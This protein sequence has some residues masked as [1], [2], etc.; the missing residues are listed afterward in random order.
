[1]L[2]GYSDS[3]F[4]YS[5][6][7][8]LL[9]ASMRVVAIDQRGHGR[10]ERA[11]DYSMD[12]MAED[13][14]GLMD[15]LDIPSATIVGHSMGSFVA[16]RVAALAPSR[17]TSLVLVGAGPSARNG[18]ILEVQKAVDALR[19]PVDPAFVREFQLSTVARPVPEAFMSAAIQESHRLDAATWKAVFAGLI[20]YVPAE[21]QIRV[22]TLVLG[23]DRDGVFSVAEQRELTRAIAGARSVIVAGVGHALHWEE[24]ERFV[25]ELLQ[26]TASPGRSGA[27][28]E[29]DAASP[30]HDLDHSAAAAGIG[31]RVLR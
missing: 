19:D 2:H 24:P 1:M 13:V 7:L 21:P 6:V 30:S 23:G 15:A 29:T 10:S 17:I 25:S 3:A 31:V 9:P 28:N 27:T 14:I 4:S 26:F 20:A 18:A 11:A 16:R 5:R 8:P 12:A 22:P